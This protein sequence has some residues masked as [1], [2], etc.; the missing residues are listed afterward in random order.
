MLVP[1]SVKVKLHDR[2]GLTG[3]R[4]RAACEWPANVEGRYDELAE[5]DLTEEE[6]DEML[7]AGEPV[8]AVG[9]PDID[10]RARFEVVR[11]GARRYGWRLST[12]DGEVLARSET[13]SSKAAAVRAAEA[14]MRA[15][16]GAALVDRTAG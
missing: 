3:A 4:V 1:D 15:S 12:P 16:L 11:D 14:V 5:F 6:F 8:E 9:P 2:R 13:F 7:A 10:R